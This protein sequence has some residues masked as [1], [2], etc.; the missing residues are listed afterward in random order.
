MKSQK[1]SCVWAGWARFARKHA[2]SIRF[3]FVTRGPVRE[4]RVDD[5]QVSICR[6]GHQGRCLRGR[7]RAGGGSPALRMKVLTAERAE[8]FVLTFGV[9]TRNPCDALAV[10]AAHQEA[11]HGL[12]D[13][14]LPVLTQPFGE[15]SVVSFEQLGRMGSECSTSMAV[16]MGVTPMPGPAGPFSAAVAYVTGPSGQLKTAPPSTRSGVAVT[17]DASSDARKRIA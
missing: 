16:S 17:N 5:L 1:A 4:Q 8:V 2:A 6:S 15:L 13:A 3:G 7:C 14:L 9:G 10:V 12:C 11:F